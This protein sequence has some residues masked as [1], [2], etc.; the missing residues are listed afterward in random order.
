MPRRALPTN[1]KEAETSRPKK[2]LALTQE[3]TGASSPEGAAV[4]L[5]ELISIM[6]WEGSDD[7]SAPAKIA[8]ALQTME[9]L[10]PRD[11]FERMLFT[12]MIALH[13]AAIE[14]FRRAM[15]GG[16]EL[17]VRESNLKLAEKLTAKFAAH[18]ETLNKHR[19]KG[20]QKVTVEHVNV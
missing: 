2:N 20:Q 19:G 6:R 10:A 13:H 3:A 12:Q 4:R 7:P 11:G 16:Q 9:E 18:M 17:A 14:C 15:N 8:N 5:N 1:P